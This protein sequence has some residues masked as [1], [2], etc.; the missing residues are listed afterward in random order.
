[1]VVKKTLSVAVLAAMLTPIYAS[2]SGDS[3]AKEMASSRQEAIT[4]GQQI[5]EPEFIDSL[6]GKSNQIQNAQIGALPKQETPIAPESGTKYFILITD[7]MGESRIKQL[8]RSLAHRQDVAFVVRGLLP[9]EKT[10]TDVG[11]RII[12]LVKN[13]PVTPNVILDPRPFQDVKAEFAPQILMYHNGELVA[14]AQGLANP[15][16]LKERVDEGK[17][18]DLGNFGSVVKIAERD[19]TEVLK[20]RFMKLDKQ[21][22]IADAKNRYWDNVQ[23]LTLPESKETQ[24]REFKPN[25][26]IDR[27]IITPDGRVIA[28]AG[29]Q[30]NTLERVPFTQRLVIFDATDE[31]QLEFAKSLPPTDLRTKYITTRFDRTLKWDAIK[32]VEDQLN[33]PV[34]QLKREIITAFDVQTVPSIV[35]ADNHRNVFLISETKLDN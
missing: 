21:Q 15:N 31:K 23:F 17:Q 7:A 11:Q 33:A 32:Y 6:I 19:I 26:Y 25:L 12:N 29:Q 9:R 8:F 3:F 34:Y 30:Y 16:Y 20:E 13:L 35:T 18:G 27:D 2:G 4:H 5:L 14:S 28:L 10:I 22:L 1:M 24:V